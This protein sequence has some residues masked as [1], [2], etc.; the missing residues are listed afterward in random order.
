MYRDEFGLPPGKIAVENGIV[1]L[2]TAYQ[3]LT[4]SGDGDDADVTDALRDLEPTDYAQRRLNCSFDPT[5]DG[6]EFRSFV[7]EVVE[8]TMIET[9]K[10][11]LGTC[12]F[13]G[14]LAEKALMLVGVVQT[15]NRRS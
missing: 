6:S 2:Q 11:Y 7:G 10:E 13:R 5:A 9:V 12:L 1:D 8:N 14:H 3:H 4:G 15:E